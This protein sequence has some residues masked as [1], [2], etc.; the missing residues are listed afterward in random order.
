MYAAL[1]AA[2]VIR[3][4]EELSGGGRRTHP[5]SDR[6]LP[7]CDGITHAEA[8]VYADRSQCR[9]TV[10]QI[11]PLTLSHERSEAPA[12]WKTA[13]LI[14]TAVG[15]G[16]TDGEQ[17]LASEAARDAWNQTRAQLEACN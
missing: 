13:A 11:S 7:D 12:S 1:I 2:Y 6:C 5:A 17:P 16:I 9:S 15:P 8:S 10:S 3:S 4:K 14:T